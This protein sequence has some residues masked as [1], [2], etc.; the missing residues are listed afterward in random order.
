MHVSHPAEGL[1]QEM[2]P[3]KCL[4][5]EKTTSKIVLTEQKESEEGERERL[6]KASPSQVRETF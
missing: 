1:A 6:R 4:I 2:H 3:I 5:S